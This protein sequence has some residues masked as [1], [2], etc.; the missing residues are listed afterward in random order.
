M[1]NAGDMATW[2]VKKQEYSGPNGPNFSPRGRRTDGAQAIADYQSVLDGRRPSPMTTSADTG[3]GPPP[4]T[5]P[6]SLSTG[7]PAPSAPAST[8]TPLS[9]A[10]AVGRR[11]LV[12]AT[13]WPQYKCH[14][15]GGIG[16]EASVL[17][18]TGVSAVVKFTFSRASD[19][20]PWES[21]RVPYAHLRPL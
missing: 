15:H 14:E 16:W 20:R 17:S 13:F 6:A 7:I 9:R 5:P 2:R 10:N 19:G 11:V 18:A 8:G 12:L 3:R 1:Q 21:E 4:P